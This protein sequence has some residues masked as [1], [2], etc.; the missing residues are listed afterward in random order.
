MRKG[1][2]IH[3]T[4]CS[5]VSRSSYSHPTDSSAQMHTDV[6]Y[7]PPLRHSHKPGDNPGT[8]SLASSALHKSALSPILAHSVIYPGKPAF[9]AV[10]ATVGSSS[11]KLPLSRAS[12][13]PGLPYHLEQCSVCITSSLARN[14]KR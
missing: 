14:I 2:L 11:P 4:G 1:D 5:Q 7:L 10:H 3:V 13:S 6:A 12:F 8:L 9:S